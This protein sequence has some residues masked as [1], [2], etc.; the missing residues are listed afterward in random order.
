M[1]FAVILTYLGQ[2]LALYFWEGFFALEY[3]PISDLS[4]ATCGALTDGYADRYLCSPGH[5]WFSVSAVSGGVML[6]LGAVIL[7]L[8]PVDVEGRSFPGLR[9]LGLTLTIAALGLIVLGAV[10]Y[11]SRTGIHASGW[12]VM[13]VALW[14]AIALGVWSSIRA[15]RLGGER[16]QAA[17]L[18]LSRP[19]LFLSVAAL[20]ISV[21]GFLV[22]L[23]APDTAPLGIY[24]RLSIDPLLLWVTAL[25]AGLLGQGSPRRRQVR[26]R[27]EV[28]R[29]EQ[30]ERDAALRKA[31]QQ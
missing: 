2:V 12:T 20:I 24:Y 1:V 10:P 7:I 26:G 13:R 6:L 17:A 19:L 21:V 11:D 15:T 23:T 4:V 14:A 9:V 18:L 25:G 30:A 29:R 22:L 27:G 8:G 5:L 28:R 31:A 3:N 16:R